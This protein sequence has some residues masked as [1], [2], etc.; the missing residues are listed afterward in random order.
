MATTMTAG[1]RRCG[2]SRGTGLISDHSSIVGSEIRSHSAMSSS[3]C[4][5]FVD[6][7]RGQTVESL[8]TVIR[9]DTMLPK[10]VGL[11]CMTVDYYNDER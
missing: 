4:R 7:R 2:C 8:L 11:Q 1:S 10:F 9:N 3:P 6:T 5:R